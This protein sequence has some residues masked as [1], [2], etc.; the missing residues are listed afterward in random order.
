VNLYDMAVMAADWQLCGETPLGDIS[1]P[2][3]G[4]DSCVDF[5]DLAVLTEQWLVSPGD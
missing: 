4:T 1:G 3:G 5:A 2:A